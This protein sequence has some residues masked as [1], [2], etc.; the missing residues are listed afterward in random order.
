MKFACYRVLVPLLLLSLIVPKCVEAEA[1]KHSS[2]VSQNS[3][4]LS[5]SLKIN[6]A[7][8]T[9][10]KSIFPSSRTFLTEN[11]PKDVKTVAQGA[12][13]Q[14]SLLQLLIGAGGIYAAYMYYGVLQEDV[15]GYT[16]ADGTKFQS[17]WF[18]QVLEAL[19]NVIVGGIGR[20]L[21]GG[22]TQGL[23]AVSTGCA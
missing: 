11:M 23:S 7:S 3:A 10:R 13:N 2:T 12:A 4:A 14:G 15:M 17:S 5:S 21:A 6:S 22:G 16:S 1:G 18:I 19:A 9:K 8:K 20:Q